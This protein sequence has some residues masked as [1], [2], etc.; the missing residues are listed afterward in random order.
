MKEHKLKYAAI[1][2]KCVYKE[3]T[4]LFWKNTSIYADARKKHTH[5]YGG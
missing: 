5:I 1:A 2:Q 3:Q 4:R